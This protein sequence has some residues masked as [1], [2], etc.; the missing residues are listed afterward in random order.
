MSVRRT[1][2]AAVPMVVGIVLAVA[3]VT[4]AVAQTEEGVTLVTAHD[5]YFEGLPTSVPAGTELTFATRA[6]S[7]TS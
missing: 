3:A 6:P 2:R 7:S 5:Y 4:P 1:L